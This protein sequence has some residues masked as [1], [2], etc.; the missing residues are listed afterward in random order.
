[1]SGK[2]VA[3]VVETLPDARAL[4]EVNRV[5]ERAVGSWKTS[6]RVKRAALPSY[7][8]D[9]FDLP[10]MRFFVAQDADGRV[11]GVATLA[12]V[13]EGEGLPGLPSRLLH[14]LFV[15]PPRTH[16]GIGRALLNAVEAAA[17]EEGVHALV[18]RAHIDSQ[19]FFAKA[20]YEAHA[21]AAYPY[22]MARRLSG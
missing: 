20:G 5:I 11:A 17:R 10:D 12:A 6:D 16:R 3:S 13:K 22:A 8:Y 19:G 18:V 15:D 14:G 1:M 4:A 7:R 2:E 21:S 9:P